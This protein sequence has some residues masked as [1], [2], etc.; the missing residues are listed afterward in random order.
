[1]VWLDYSLSLQCIDYTP[2]Q[3][4]H[5][6]FIMHEVGHQVETHSHKVMIS[7]YSLPLFVI[8]VALHHGCFSVFTTSQLKFSFQ[9][10]QI[11]LHYMKHYYIFLCFITL[12]MLCL[13]KLNLHY[14]YIIYYYYYETLGPLYIS[15][16]PLLT[17]QLSHTLYGDCSTIKDCEI[18][19]LEKVKSNPK[20]LSHIL[21]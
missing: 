4:S 11:I 2:S 13:Y 3:S 6:L 7:L 15:I 20:L 1:M 17:I 12:L 9:Y 16:L 21:Y 5:T 14:Y 8:K 19:T 10:T 18:I